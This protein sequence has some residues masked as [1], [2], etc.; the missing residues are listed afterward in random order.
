MK[1]ILETDVLIIGSGIAGSTAGLML[2]E[3]GI[4]TTIISKGEDFSETNT[5]W[6]QGGI[7]CLNGDEDP[8]NFVNDI[9][10]SGDHIN[11]IPAVR[12]IVDFSYSL[13]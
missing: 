9:L 8:K 11:H 4:N 3:K 2:A 7:A 13:V 12:Q 5:N 6:A 10:K 1:E